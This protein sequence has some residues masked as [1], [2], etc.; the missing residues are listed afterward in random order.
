[1]KE[2]KRLLAITLIG[3]V[4]ATLMLVWVEPKTLDAKVLQS[5]FIIFIYLIGKEYGKLQ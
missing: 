5:L 4:I 3:L 2:I 1:M